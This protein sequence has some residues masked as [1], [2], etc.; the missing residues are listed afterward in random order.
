MKSGN[1]QDIKS[2]SVLRTAKAEK[3]GHHDRHKDDIIDI[4]LMRRCNSNYIKVVGEPFH[5]YVYSTEQLEIVN[6]ISTKLSLPI[7]HLDA[8]G[9][10]VR[11]P[12]YVTKKIYYY[13]GVVKTSISRV[14]PIFEMYSCNPRCNIDWRMAS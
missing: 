1:Y 4:L 7:L 12:P 6:S 8:T 13:S 2:D 11:K 3:R 5:V 10:I 14:C 9:S